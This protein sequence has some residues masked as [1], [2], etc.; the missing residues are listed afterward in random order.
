MP[1]QRTRQKK[2]EAA[3]AAAEAK[4]EAA[5]PKAAAKPAPVPTP[6]GGRQRGVCRWFVDKK[7]YGFISS[8]DGRDIFVH[9]ADLKEAIG[10][11]DTVEY[12]VVDF[13]GRPKAIEVTKISG[14]EPPK[15]PQPPTPP[16]SPP[17]IMQPPP[18]LPAPVA[19][20]PPPPKPQGPPPRRRGVCQWFTP[21][22]K[23]GFIKPDGGGADVF[24]HQMDLRAGTE[25]TE[26]DTV[27]FGTADYKGREKAVDVIKV[28]PAVRAAAPRALAPPGVPA[29]PRVNIA[30]ARPWPKVDAG[31]Q[32]ASAPA[33]ASN[34]ASPPPAAPPATGPWGARAAAPAAAPAAARRP[35]WGAADPPAAAPA[36][37][38][39]PTPP[40]P[41]PAPKPRPAGPRGWG[42]VDS[43]PSFAD[44]SAGPTPGEAMRRA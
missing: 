17:Q 13:K 41:A 28:D 38:P 37:P 15:P 14:K 33:P 21:K 42:Q 9:G 7:K 10:E 27:E 40:A 16:P 2:K 43:K 39:A 26:G 23:H 44:A 20:R 11:G 34:G 19:P 18:A 1:N 24:V 35:S 31:L 12:A 32:A 6:P 3:A 36:S 30:P 22:K 4:K 25:I 5:K 29:K 8:G